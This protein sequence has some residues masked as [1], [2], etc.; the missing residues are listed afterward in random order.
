MTP[1]GITVVLHYYT[2]PEA[3]PNSDAPAVREMVSSLIRDGI[4]GREALGLPFVTDRGRAW[5]EL[6]L[7]TPFPR[8]AW[9]DENGND[10]LGET[11]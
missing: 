1:L 4:L 6:L 10:I 8:M 7:R 3:L 2:T 9:V 11:K 5:I